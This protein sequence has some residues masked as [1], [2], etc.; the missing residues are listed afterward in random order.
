MD[1]RIN[2]QKLDSMVRWKGFEAISSYHG[3]STWLHLICIWK[4][5]SAVGNKQVAGLKNIKSIKR[6]L[7]SLDYQPFL[8][9]YN[10][11]SY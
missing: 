1:K 8:F 7:L 4:L 5:I 9:K 11:C 6:I 10:L 2:C 3:W